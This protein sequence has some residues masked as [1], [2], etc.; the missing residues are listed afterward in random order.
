MPTTVCSPGRAA[1]RLRV[2]LPYHCHDP[3]IASV[4]LVS[5]AASAISAA[6]SLDGEASVE[7]PLNAV[8]PY[9]V[10]AKGKL[11]MTS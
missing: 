3:D 4:S 5:S 11:Y 6:N 2:S 10:A 1:P 8:A 9:K 7:E